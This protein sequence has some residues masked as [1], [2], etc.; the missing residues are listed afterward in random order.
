MARIGD[1]PQYA[2]LFT[3]NELAQLFEVAPKTVRRW[4]RVGT[5]PTRPDGSVGWTYTPGGEYRFHADAVQQITRGGWRRRL[6]GAR[7]MWLLDVEE[8]DDVDVD[9]KTIPKGGGTPNTGGIV[10]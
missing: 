5:F 8:D 7:L 4:V 10:G 2:D 1:F 3:V 9:E 6:L